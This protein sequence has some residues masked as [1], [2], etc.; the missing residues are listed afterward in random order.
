MKENSY[1]EKYLNSKNGSKLE[2]IDLS[3]PEDKTDKLP[4]VTNTQIIQGVLESFIENEKVET[5]N[6]N[7]GLQSTNA[8]VL[9]KHL[10]I[11]PLSRRC[12]LKLEN[13]EP[14]LWKITLKKGESSVDFNFNSETKEVV[15]IL[16]T[17]ISRNM[18]QESGLLENPSFEL[19]CILLKLEADVFLGK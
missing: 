12:S 15:G 13:S 9:K 4:V 8:A 11:T 10:R 6:F 7:L 2:V 3:G 18:F 1:F 19:A 5:L 14:G 16:K 17:K